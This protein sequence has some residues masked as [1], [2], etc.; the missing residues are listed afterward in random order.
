MEKCDSLVPVYIQR[1]CA[2]ASDLKM[3]SCD[4]KTLLCG[5]ETLR[6]LYWAIWRRLGLGIER[7]EDAFAVWRRIGLVC[8]VLVLETSLHCLAIALCNRVCLARVLR[9]CAV[10]CLWAL[11]IAFERCG[12]A[13]ERCELPLCAMDCFLRY[14]VALCCAF[15]GELWSQDLITLS[16][17]VSRTRFFWGIWPVVAGFDLL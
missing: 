2:G 14:D 11:W 13:F 5:F 4:F 16:W 12:F 8:F 3:L 9:V 17:K 15:V 6:P 7:F 10:D 1:L